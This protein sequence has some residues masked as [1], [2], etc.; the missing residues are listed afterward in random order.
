MCTLPH[1]PLYS[2]PACLCPS[3]PHVKLILKMP[4]AI[5]CLHVMWSRHQLKM[6]ASAEVSEK[7]HFNIPANLRLNTMASFI[8]L[9]MYCQNSVFRQTHTRDN[10]CNP[11]CA[12]APRVNNAHGSFN[13]FVSTEHSITREINSL[14]G[15]IVTAMAHTTV[16]VGNEKH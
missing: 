13:Y 8:I 6:A 16:H 3:C 1:I 5:P 4:S 7:C 9:L 11:L 15:A 14:S 12:C 10:Y 2:L